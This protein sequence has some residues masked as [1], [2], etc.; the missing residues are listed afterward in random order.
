MNTENQYHTKLTGVLCLESF[1]RPVM[2]SKETVWT[3]LVPEE[4][5]NT[6]NT[7]KEVASTYLVERFTSG[8]Q[9]HG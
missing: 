7:K 9:P 3:H 5:E 8:V 6:T 4:D 1:K 2:I